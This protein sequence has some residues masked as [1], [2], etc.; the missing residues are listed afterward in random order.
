MTAT[1]GTL[2]AALCIAATPARALRSPGPL[3]NAH[4]SLDSQEQCTACHTDGKSLSNDKCLGCHEHEPLRRRI[5]EHKGFHASD[6][7]GSKQCFLC[8]SEHKGK[9]SDIRGFAAIGG[10]GKF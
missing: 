3:S 1:R 7:V 6:K 5:S 10:I 2:L 4:A 8:H 9:G